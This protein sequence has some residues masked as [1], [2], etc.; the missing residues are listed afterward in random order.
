MHNKPIKLLPSFKEHSMPAVMLTKE[1]LPELLKRIDNYCHANR[2][3]IA[4]YEESKDDV[5]RRKDEICIKQEFDDIINLVFGV[6][7]SNSSELEHAIINYACVLSPISQRLL[8]NCPVKGR[9][10]HNIKASTINM[11][12]FAMNQAQSNAIVE[13]FKEK[14]TPSMNIRC[15][16]RNKLTAELKLDFYRPGFILIFKIEDFLTILKGIAISK[17]NSI[18]VQLHPPIGKKHSGFF[19]LPAPLATPLELRT[20]PKDFIPELFVH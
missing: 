7:Q 19:P 3:A 5:G 18:E 15:I 8:K 16:S 14:Q 13:I 1:T 6:G 17:V 11:E 2:T 12:Y 4:K 20:M 9:A 10:V